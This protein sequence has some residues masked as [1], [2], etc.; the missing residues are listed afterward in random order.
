MRIHL[1]A[2]FVGGVEDDGVAWDGTPLIPDDLSRHLAQTCPIVPRCFLPGV[3]LI[4]KWEHSSSGLVRFVLRAVM[5]GGCGRGC[6]DVWELCV[7]ERLE[8]SFLLGL[9]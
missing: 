8:G 2:T 4:E 6:A 1:V 9:T 7:L 5:A 3:G